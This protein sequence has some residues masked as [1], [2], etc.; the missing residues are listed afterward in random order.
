MNEKNTTQVSIAKCVIVNK[1]TCF[2]TVVYYIHMRRRTQERLQNYFGIQRKV[3]R[4]RLIHENVI[5]IK[6]VQ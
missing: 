2:A 5:G 4:I 1:K 3:S 6:N